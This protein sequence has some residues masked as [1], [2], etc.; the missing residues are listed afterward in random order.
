L[1]KNPRLEGLSLVPQL[2]D[3]TATRDR[4][5]ITSSYF[6]NH[7]VRSRDWRLIS[8]QDGARELY[9]HRNDPNEFRNLAKDPKHQAVIKRLAK[10]L[11]KKAAPE[12]R[13]KSERLRLRK[14]SKRCHARLTTMLHLPT[15]LFSH[16]EA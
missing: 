2:K 1:P 10:W 14:K 9:D 6:G 3:P 12:F 11:P 5:A 7:S 15:E 4:P 16:M 8:Y 13:E